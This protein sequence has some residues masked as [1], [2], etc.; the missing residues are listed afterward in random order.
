MYSRKLPPPKGSILLFGP[1]GTGKST[2]IR[3]H[4][5]NVPTYDLL[6]T[7]ESLRLSKNPGT[8]YTEL[9]VVDKGSWVV[10]DEIQK[11]PELLDEVHRLI[12]ERQLRFILS[13]S[14]AR[15]LKRGGANLLAGRAIMTQMFPL[16]SAEVNFKIDGS[17]VFPFGMLPVAYQQ[18]NPEDYLRTYGEAYL[19][20]EIKGEALTRNIGGFA[21]FLEVAARQNAQVTN[22]AN[23]ARDAQVARL[24]VQGYFDILKDT[25]I[26]DWLPA[27]KMRRATKQIAHP[28]FYFFD[29]GVA[30]A[31]SGRLPYPPL[32]E[33]LGFLLETFLLNEL[34]AY[35]AY[36]KKFYPLYFWS[37]HDQVEVDFFCETA[38]GFVAIEVKGANRWESKFNRGLKR[39]SEELK[40][41]V[42]AYGV[43]TG[44]RAS[45]SDLSESGKI[46]I[47][48]YLD[49][50]KR[51][52]EGEIL[53]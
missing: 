35:L 42:K 14:S 48:P 4:F 13:G 11:V 40:G 31:L 28:K 37:S 5:S 26:G 8:F 50:L 46:S 41:K 38:R 29:S 25:L 20:E 27:W 45:Q 6:N 52:W 36:S 17:R 24:T 51:L 49:F 10:V 43:Y 30:R 23:I 1:R 3:E 39:M 44:Q 21:R 16:I 7:T 22:V 2:W 53:V 18:D 34:K 47:L 33:E 32:P 19:Q 15:K 9:Q 12:E